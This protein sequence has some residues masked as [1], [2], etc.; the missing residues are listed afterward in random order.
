IASEGPCRSALGAGV[1][2]PRNTISTKLGDAGGAVY[3]CDCAPKG[4]ADAMQRSTKHR[5]RGRRSTAGR[6]RM[7]KPPRVG[8]VFGKVYS[9]KPDRICRRGFLTTGKELA[10]QAGGGAYWLS[11]CPDPD[12][13]S[14]G[15]HCGTLFL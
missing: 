5:E 3:C 8:G 9:L 15:Y 2:V 14:S 13:R 4:T 6:V 7:S 1:P 12:H 11:V 10:H